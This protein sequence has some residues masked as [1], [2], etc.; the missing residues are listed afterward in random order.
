MEVLM[1]ERLKYKL[2]T[3]D[4]KE[5]VDEFGDCIGYIIKGANEYGEVEVSWKPSNLKYF[6]PLKYLDIIDYE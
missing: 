4:S 1:S 5:H 2:I 6:Y 3:N